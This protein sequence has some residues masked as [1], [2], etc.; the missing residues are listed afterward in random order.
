MGEYWD[1]L[2][3]QGEETGKR[4]RRT[5]YNQLASGEYHLVVH[6]WIVNSKG[7]F[8]IQRRSHNRIPMPGEWAAT[9][10]SVFS[11]RIPRRP[12]S[13]SFGKRWASVCSR[14]RFIICGSSSAKI[15]SSIFGGRGVT[16]PSSSLCLE[17]KEVEEAKWVTAET[18]RTM[19]QKKEFHNYGRSYFSAVFS[20]AREQYGSGSAHEMM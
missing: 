11:G 8:L 4:L 2:N 19:I 14:E 15:P 9:G 13:A 6:I 17:P 16:A 10:G 12:P 18:L 20:L 3:E 5:V 7:A 1:V